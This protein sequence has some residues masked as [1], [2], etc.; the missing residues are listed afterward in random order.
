VYMATRHGRDVMLPRFTEMEISLDRPLELNS[1][2][3][4]G[5]AAAAA[6]GK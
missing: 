4:A 3:K 5:A 6:A 2:V 1:A